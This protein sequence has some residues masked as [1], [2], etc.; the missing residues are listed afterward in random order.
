MSLDG[1]DLPDTPCVVV[2]LDVAEANIDRHQSYCDAHGLKA[3]PHIKTHKT[4]ELARRQVAAGAVGITCQKLGEVEVMTRAGLADVLIT[5]NILG[6]QKLARLRALPARTTLA[7]TADNATVVAG[8]SEAWA[9]APAPLT[10][11]VECD[12]GAR[13]CGVPDPA[14]A[15]ALARTIDAAPGLAFGGLMTYPAPGDTA[16]VEA[17]MTE[18]KAGLTHAG[19]D[20][21]TVSSGGTPDMAR[22][23]E[24]TVVTEYRAGTYV[25]NDRSLVE[26]GACGWDDCALTVLATVV[27]VPAPDRAVI[28]AGSKV[29][30]TDPMGLTGHGHVLDRPDLAIDRLSEEHGCIQALDGTVDLRVGERVRVVPNHAC[31]VVNM[32][33][34]VVTLRGGVPAGTMAVAARGRVA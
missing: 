27:S 11:L 7:V 18:A 25:Y 26:R 30:T 24:A 10:V 22:A 19:L 32:V 12:T 31:V 1:P 17:W 14:A 23:H 34:R 29:L 2:D 4:V 6:P 8:L 15:V 33:D 16:A 3:R 5:Y 20:C 9:V 21:P 13:R 28:D